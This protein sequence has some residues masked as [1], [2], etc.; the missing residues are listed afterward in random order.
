MMKTTTLTA[1][2]TT[3]V[4]AVGAANAAMIIWNPAVDIIDDVSQISTNG[5]LHQSAA[6]VSLGGGGITGASV[7]VN[8][9]AFPDNET[10]DA[11]DRNDF[12]SGATGVTGDYNTLLN[13]GDRVISGDAAITFTGLTIGTPYEIQFWAS[14]TRNAAQ[15]GLV[16]NDG[17]TANS[18]DAFNSDHATVLID[19]T[20]GSSA[21]QFVIGTFTADSSSQSLLVRRW[22]NF[23]T[24]PT[25]SFQTLV[26]AWQVRAIPEPSSIALLGLGGLLVARRRRA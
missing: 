16:L 22:D 12:I 20:P 14:D 7:T 26:Q 19:V 3:T 21:G 15:D 24:T 23:D 6:G 17:G 9:V 1:L 25:A 10:L 18:P 13:N 5:T 8:G 2:I 11:P 4:L